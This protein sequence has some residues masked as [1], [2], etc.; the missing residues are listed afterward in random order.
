MFT[1][2]F[3]LSV[4][5]AESSPKQ[6]V[7]LNRELFDVSDLSLTRC[8]CLALLWRNLQSMAKH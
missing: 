1:A 4:T 2:C 3:T 5:R 8:Q 7:R 6:N